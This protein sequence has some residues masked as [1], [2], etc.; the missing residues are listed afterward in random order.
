MLV[1]LGLGGDAFNLKSSK[2]S[3]K[4]LRTMGLGVDGFDFKILKPSR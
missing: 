1:S 3:S 4:L 2:P